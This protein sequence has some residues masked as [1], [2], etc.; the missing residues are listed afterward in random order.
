MKRVFKKEENFEWLPLDVIGVIAKMCIEDCIFSFGALCLVSTDFERAARNPSTPYRYL[1]HPDHPGIFDRYFLP[2]PSDATRI[3]VAKKAKTTVRSKTFRS[4]EGGDSP[5]CYDRYKRYPAFYEKTTGC[6][7]AACKIASSAAICSSYSQNSELNG[8]LCSHACRCIHETLDPLMFYVYSPNLSWSEVR[9]KDYPH[10][11]K[12]EPKQ[13]ALIT[14]RPSNFTKRFE[15]FE[16]T[17][18]EDQCSCDDHRIRGPGKLLDLLMIPHIQHQKLAEPEK[19]SNANYIKRIWHSPDPPGS[20]ANFYRRDI[21]TDVWSIACYHYYLNNKNES[22]LKSFSPWFFDAF[23]PRDYVKIKPLPKDIAEREEESDDFLTPNSI[24]RE[25]CECEKCNDPSLV[26]GTIGFL[27]LLSECHPNVNST[28]KISTSFDKVKE[29][30]ERECLKHGERDFWHVLTNARTRLIFKEFLMDLSFSKENMALVLW[31][32]RGCASPHLSAETLE[33]VF[34]FGFLS[35]Y[36]GNLSFLLEEERKKTG[37]ESNLRIFYIDILLSWVRSKT[38]EDLKFCLHEWCK[39]EDENDKWLFDD[40]VNVVRRDDPKKFHESVD[41]LVLLN[42]CTFGETFNT[43]KCFENVVRVM[44][45]DAENVKS[46]FMSVQKG[47]FE[48]LTNV[49]N[50]DLV[51]SISRNVKFFG[52]PISTQLLDRLHRLN[53]K[54]PQIDY[55]AIPKNF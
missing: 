45:K 46:Y 11:F 25:Y 9:A 43:I 55:Y 22:H 10:H 40:V 14:K 23:L 21:G 41:W 5:I 7:Q 53:F 32:L 17:T 31:I 50:A 27:V 3:T 19:R 34:G 16:G 4:E 49:Q 51:E 39:S 29:L 24:V 47:S 35:I 38:K 13:F 30:V 2:Y 18:Q 52:E 36:F 15:A 37:I 33:N 48:G 1:H 42:A 44:E 54:S 26:S 8:M 20:R 28:T 12:M 6:W